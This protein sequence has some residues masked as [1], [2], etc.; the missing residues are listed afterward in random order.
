MRNK[1]NYFSTLFKHCLLIDMINML[2]MIVYE[3]RVH[4]NQEVF[5]IQND[6]LTT[7][8]IMLMHFLLEKMST[9]LMYNARRSQMIKR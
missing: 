2:Y 1:T 8:T 9:F 3:R 7:A 6:G 4:L 5:E